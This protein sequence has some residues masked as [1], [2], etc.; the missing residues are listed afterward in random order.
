MELA[1]QGMNE[2]MVLQVGLNISIVE[3]VIKS[4]NYILL[5]NKL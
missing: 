1:T 4:Q 2:L 5:R 3:I